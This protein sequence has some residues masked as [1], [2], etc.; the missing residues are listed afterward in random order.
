M[1]LFDILTGVGKLAS[2]F[3]GGGS[4]KK[5][6]TN[7]NQ[8]TTQNSN[9]VGS[10]TANRREFSDGMLALL[11]TTTANQIAGGAVGADALAA[12]IAKVRGAGLTEGKINFDAEKYIRD[13]MTGVDNSLG[14][15]L[16]QD[17][18]QAIASAGGS[19]NSAAALLANRLEQ[20][21]AA[22]RAGILGT[23]TANATSIEAAARASNREDLATETTLLSGLDTSMQSGLATL[24]NA[25]R[26]GE[27]YQEVNNK[28]VTNA[29]GTSSGTATSKT[30]F[31]WTS[32]LGNIFKDVNQD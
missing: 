32:G 25:L 27:T 8:S 14:A 28:E 10:T 30:P 11:E 9:T 18:N 2:N 24:L 31:N 23:T 4:G 20:D 16:R 22:Q 13:T 17:R 6:T 19:S 26:G 21:N 12:Q 5:E 1:A 3:L 7:S 15:T 29:S